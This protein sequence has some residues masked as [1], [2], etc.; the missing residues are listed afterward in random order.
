MPQLLKGLLNFGVQVQVALFKIHVVAL[1]L[2]QVFMKVLVSLSAWQSHC[3]LQQYKLCEINNLRNVYFQLKQL[4]KD[5]LGGIIWSWKKVTI[6][7]VSH[8]ITIY[9]KLQYYSI[10][11]QVLPVAQIAKAFF[12][13]TV[14]IHLFTTFIYFKCT[15]YFH[16]WLMIQ[17]TTLNSYTY[18]FI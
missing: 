14:Y 15:K 1:D 6:C 13:Y 17:E 5:S 8:N 10:M 9:L 11:T 12:I 2:W 3:A 16:L 18:V 4:P 7:N